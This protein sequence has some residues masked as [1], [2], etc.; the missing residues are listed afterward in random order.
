MA[1]PKTAPTV[2]QKKISSFFTSKS[3]ST[4][5]KQPSTEPVL[6]SSRSENLQKRSLSLTEQDDQLNGKHL[7]KSSTAALADP[8]QTNHLRND[9]RH[10]LTCP[11]SISPV[12]HQRID[13]DN[14]VQHKMHEGRM[15]LAFLTSRH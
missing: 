1:G 10:Q 3:T 9:R 2:A 4:P 12:D 14:Q 15:I 5:H 7:A 8:L 11:N 6:L 13:K